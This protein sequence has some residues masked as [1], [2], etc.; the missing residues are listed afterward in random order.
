M[1][2]IKDL[3]QEIES[4]PTDRIVIDYEYQDVVSKRKIL[5]GIDGVKEGLRELY[6]KLCKKRIGDISADSKCF[7]IE[8]ILGAE[9]EEIL[10]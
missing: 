6:I 5:E 3:K 9:P 4:L 1:K 8:R 10:K 7:L 2:T